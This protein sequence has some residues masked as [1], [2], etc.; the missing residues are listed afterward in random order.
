MI[1]TYRRVATSYWTDPDIRRRVRSPDAHAVLLYLFTGPD[2]NLAGLYHQPP[3]LAASR[4]RVPVDR[5]TAL[6]AEFTE[7]GWIAYDPDTEEVLVVNAIR[8]Q[9]GDTVKP[10]D[11]RWRAIIR[12]VADAHS[13]ALVAAIIDAYPDAPW[14][15]DFVEKSEPCGNP[16]GGSF[17]HTDPDAEGA[18][19]PLMAN[20]HATIDA[21]PEPE[22]GRGPDAR[23][24]AVS[25]AVEVTRHREGVAQLPPEPTAPVGRVDLS[26]RVTDAVLRAEAVAGMGRGRWTRAIDLMRVNREI[27]ELLHVVDR[28]NLL[29]AMRGFVRFRDEGEFGLDPDTAY[30]PRVLTAWDAKP[31]DHGN[32]GVWYGEGD[33]RT[34][35]RLLDLCMERERNADPKRRP[36]TRTDTTTLASIADILTQHIT[37]SE[38]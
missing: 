33:Q 16:P 8:Y 27:Q 35:R 38:A 2:T 26:V 18:P 24:G 29:A 7:A 36:T 3:D 11:K 13:A 22:R 37:P 5:V 10:R 21:A 23:A 1:R 12:A 25:G 32:P 19:M 14:P 20:E 28:E 34:K 15:E 17:P 9:C 6:Y 4:T 30:T 31:D